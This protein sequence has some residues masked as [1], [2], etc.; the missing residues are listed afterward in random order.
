AV[1]EDS[2]RVEKSF[3]QFVPPTT[4]L[5]N[6]CSAA[7]AVLLPLTFL[8]S[9]ALCLCHHPSLFQMPHLCSV[10]VRDYMKVATM[11]VDSA[12]LSRYFNGA[13]LKALIEPGVK[14]ALIV[15]IAI[16]VLQMGFYTTLLK[17]VD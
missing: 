15:G 1:C 14:H 2:S 7:L 16:Q 10:Y 12:G 4:F 6:L 17:F 3:L 8:H 13:N 5:C 9:S 11:L